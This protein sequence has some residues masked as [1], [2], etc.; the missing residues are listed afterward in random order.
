MGGGDLA[1]EFGVG[2]ANGGE[3]VGGDFATVDGRGRFGGSASASDLDI[4][5]ERPQ[6][7]NHKP[8]RNE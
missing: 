6:N 3:F 7:I 1:G 5:Q 8:T 4:G 2:D